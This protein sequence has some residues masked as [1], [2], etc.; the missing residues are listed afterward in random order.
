MLKR[1][2][3]I[4]RICFRTIYSKPKRPLGFTMIPYEEQ[5]ES[6]DNE[7]ETKQKL[8]NDT[9]QETQQEYP[10]W[11]AAETAAYSISYGKWL[12]ENKNTTSIERQQKIK[13]FL[14]KTHHNKNSFTDT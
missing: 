14:D 9:L 13:E 8:K 10:L 11:D 4:S 12:E 6:R 1:S 2:L 7:N 5:Y 3:L